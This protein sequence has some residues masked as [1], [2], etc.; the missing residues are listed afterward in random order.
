MF[1]EREIETK[2]IRRKKK[3]PNSF[4]VTMHFCLFLAIFRVRFLTVKPSKIFHE[5]LY[6]YK[7]WSDDVQII[8]TFYFATV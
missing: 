8:L 6:K 7:L 5:T 3:L 2:K 1:R 4:D